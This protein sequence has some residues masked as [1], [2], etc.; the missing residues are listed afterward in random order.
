MPPRTNRTRVVITGMGAITPL[1]LTLDGFWQNLLAGKSGIG[2]VTVFDASQYR[3]RIAG[4]VK[5]FDATRYNI[6]AKDAR[7]MGRATLFALAAAKDALD[8]AGLKQNLGENP[9]AGV[10]LG[11]GL[12]GFV[13]AIK[14]H[15]AYTRQGAGRVSPFLA[16]VILPNMPAF[17]V[18][19]QHRARGFNNTVVTSCAAGT[20]AIGAATE[21]IRRGAADVMLAGGT[22]A[23]ISDIVFTAFG[24]MRALS[25]RND[26]PARACRPFDKNRDGLVIGEGA[27]IVILESLEHARVR[28]ARI[29]AEIIGYAANS[30]AYHFV[31]SDPQAIGATQVMRDGLA[32]AGISHEQIDYINAHGTATM[33]NDPSETLA[34]KNVFGERAYQVPISATKSMIGHTMGAAGALEAVVCALTIRDQKIH[35]TA[36]YETPDP[37]CDLDYVPNVARAA[38]VAIAMSNS[39]GFGG[40]NAC[41]ILARYQ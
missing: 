24:A 14:E 38:K 9:R 41:L 22:D 5:Q 27:A 11:T 2:A 36:N 15:D 39:F 7:R 16:A 32:D 4:E 18:A 6:E 35:P 33:L 21:V 13:E 1:G 20:D 40:Q 29:Y 19:N 31:A 26:D 37:V 30:D 28:G 17:Y 23:I 25:T 34:V 12:G 3:T 8:D 10:V